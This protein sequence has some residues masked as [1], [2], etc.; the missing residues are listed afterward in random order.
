MIRT[1]FYRSNFLCEKIGGLVIVDEPE[2]VNNC[3]PLTGKEITKTYP[4]SDR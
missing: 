3:S 4:V 2:A 1:K